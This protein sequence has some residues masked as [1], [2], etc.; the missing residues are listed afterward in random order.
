MPLLTTARESL[1]TAIDNWPELQSN[2]SSVFHQTYRFDDETPL[3]QELI[4]SLS[5]LPALAI[6]PASASPVWWTNEMQQWP[7]LYDLVLWTPCWN[8]ATAEDL[9]EKV[10]NAIYRATPPESSVPYVKQATG[11]Y[12]ARLG[13]ITFA[14]VDAGAV[15][16]PLKI[17]ETKASI[18][19]RTNKDP[20]AG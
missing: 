14:R 17:T 13:P 16:R 5:R 11:Y 15:D 9:I 20:F 18:T 12:P 6:F 3:L 19:L 2:G 10:I 8:I 7:A 1:W 4:P